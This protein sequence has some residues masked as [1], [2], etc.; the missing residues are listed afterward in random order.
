MKDLSKSAGGIARAEKLSKER[1]SEIAKAAVT[2]NWDPN[3]PQASHQGILH[4]GNKKIDCVVTEE[5]ERILSIKN[6][7][8]TFGRTQRGY[9]RVEQGVIM[10]P[11]MDALNIRPFI[12]TLLHELIKPIE[13]RDLKGKISRG[14]KAEILPQICLTYLQA[15][16][17]GVITKKQADMVEASHILIVAFSTVGIIALV[18]EATGYQQDRIKDA[19][20]KILQGYIASA[21]Q[22]W[23]STIPLAYYKELFRL[24]GLEYNENSVKRPRYFGHITNNIIYSRLAPGVLDELKKVSLRD[25]KGR[26]KHRYFQRL[27]SNTGYIKLKE[28]LASIVSVMKLSTDYNDFKN[29]LDRIHPVCSIG[30]ND[31]IDFEKDNGGQF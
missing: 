20:S 16:S 18:D 3:I 24:R 23:V 9:R 5:G 10:P 13:Y 21:L 31:S 17:A 1:R 19:L 6:V 30:D 27:T 15:D 11:F 12:S 28:H 22:P 29:K 4:I 8:E 25:E 26:L 7:F 14:Y 2:K